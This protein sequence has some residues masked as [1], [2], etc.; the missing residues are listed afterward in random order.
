M[1]ITVRDPLADNHVLA[2]FEAKSCDLRLE[3]VGLRTTAET[4][5]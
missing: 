3:K 5:R 4:L 1:H 2:G